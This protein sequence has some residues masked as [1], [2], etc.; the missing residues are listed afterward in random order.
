MD[1]TLVPGIYKIYWD[2]GGFSIAAVGINS[3]NGKNWLAPTNWCSFS[4][5]DPLVDTWDPVTQVEL[6]TTQH[7]PDPHGDYDRAMKGVV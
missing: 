2:T 4:S 3:K 6:I 1:K 5:D 7:S